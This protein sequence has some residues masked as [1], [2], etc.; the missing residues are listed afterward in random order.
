MTNYNEW[1][2]FFD[3]NA[4]EYKDHVFVKN[5]EAEIEF[6]IEEFDLPENSAILDMGCGTGRHSIGLANKGFLITGVDWSEGMLQQAHKN[7]DENGVDINWIY[8][9]A[10]KYSSPNTYD[11]AICLCE[12][13]FGLLLKDEDP[14]AHDHAIL[15]NIYNSLKPGS[16]LI[17]GCLN[18]L[19]KIRDAKQEDITAGRFDPFTLV[20]TFTISYKLPDGG[21]QRVTLQEH[22]FLPGELSKLVESVGFE[23]KHVW[24]GTAGSWK[25]ELFDLD[26]IELMVVATKPA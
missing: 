4:P 3:N 12:G 10:T 23:V 14:V 24:S 13:A 11:A 19:R 7:A 17:L 2:E 15:S 22:G 1:K 9:D 21:K 20:E 5:T 26:D 25:R 8:E 6:L 18:G 16:K